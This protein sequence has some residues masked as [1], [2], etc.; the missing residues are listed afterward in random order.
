MT[1][2]EFEERLRAEGIEFPLLRGSRPEVY[3]NILGLP[4]PGSGSPVHYTEHHVLIAAMWDAVTKVTGPPA[5]N[6]AALV[7]RAVYLGVSVARGWVVITNNNVFWTSQPSPKI[8]DGGA[9]A[10]RVP[11]LKGAA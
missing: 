5:N 6:K 8:F 7:R 11:V 4:N 9:V 3:R 10:V 2:A 1:L